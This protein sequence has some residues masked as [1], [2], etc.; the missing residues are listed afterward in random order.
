MCSTNFHWN[1][2]FKLA[3]FESVKKYP[4]VYLTLKSVNETLLQIFVEDLI[5]FH[6]Q[7]ITVKWGEEGES[8]N[9]SF[10]SCH[11][12]YLLFDAKFC[13]SKIDS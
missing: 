6:F 10:N 13:A 8:K 1:F 2:I 11:D 7:E 3:P 9:M 5:R 12:L 4:G